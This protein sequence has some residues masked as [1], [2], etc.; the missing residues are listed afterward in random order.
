M[1]GI[2]FRVRKPRKQVDLNVVSLVDVLFLLLIFFMLTSTFKRAGELDLKLPKS[3]TAAPTHAAASDK[4]VDLVLTEQ[5][6]LLLDGSPTTFDKLLPG[7]RALHERQPDGQVMIEAEEAVPHGQVVK[8]LDAVRTAG[9]KG[10]G[11]AVRAN[12]GAAA[13]RGR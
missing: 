5:G 12:R 3:S 1:S 6:T 11:I 9:F 10:V 8:L 13:G 7:L 2:V 4:P